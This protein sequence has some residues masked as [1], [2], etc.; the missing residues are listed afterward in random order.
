MRKFL[1]VV[2]MVLA[3][4]GVFAEDPFSVPVIPGVE[5]PEPTERKIALDSM[6]D[7][8][9]MVVRAAQLFPEL[10]Q[11]LKIAE[12]LAPEAGLYFY[13][14]KHQKGIVFFEDYEVFARLEAQDEAIFSKRLEICDITYTRACQHTSGGHPMCYTDCDRNNTIIYCYQVSPYQY[15]AKCG[16]FRDASGGPFADSQGCGECDYIFN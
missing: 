1:F 6:M 2:A 10:E 4:T 16:C 9:D 5:E 14:F 8:A 12:M 15:R 7:R 3:A 11:Q 13:R